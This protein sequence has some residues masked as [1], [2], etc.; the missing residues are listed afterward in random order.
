MNTQNPE[1]MVADMPPEALAETY[2]IMLAYHEW[3][4]AGLHEFFK[5]KGVDPEEFTNFLETYDI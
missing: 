4:E 3:R 2:E 5:A 1:L